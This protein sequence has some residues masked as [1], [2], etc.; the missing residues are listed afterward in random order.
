MRFE[1][2]KIPARD[3]Y[4]LAATVYPPTADPLDPTEVPNVCTVGAHTSYRKVNV[5]IR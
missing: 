3:G 1:V 4:D 2:K 5:P